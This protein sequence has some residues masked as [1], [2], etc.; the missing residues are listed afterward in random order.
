MK[1]LIISLLA[2][3]FVAFNVRANEENSAVFIDNEMFILDGDEGELYEVINAASLNVR[4]GPSTNNKII[5]KLQ[6]GDVISVT[7]ITGGWA[8][9]NLDGKT[10]YVS[11]AYLK[12]VE[13]KEESVKVGVSEPV[14]TPIVEHQDTATNFVPQQNQKDNKPSFVLAIKFDFLKQTKKAPGYNSFS[15][16]GV[17]NPFDWRGKR[18]SYTAQLGFLLDFYWHN[19]T[20][21]YVK[22]SSK[23]FGI[24]APLHLVGWQFN[25][26]KGNGVAIHGGFEFTCR[27]A[28][29]TKV[30]YDGSELSSANPFSKK[31]MGAG[32]LKHFAAGFAA[33]V[34]VCFFHIYGSVGYK[35]L[36]PMSK[37]TNCY[38]PYFLVGYCF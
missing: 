3:L 2:V 20:E 38:G 32:R 16:G 27:I 36:T 7:K 28:G 35:M 24:T 33:A 10:A 19:K 23:Y 11:K 37:E 22:T 25:D 5:G 15:I 13:K 6:K 21:H 9:F 17:T 4:S 1:K 34:D 8:R 30:Y 14:Q 31:D 26:G 18:S 12:K 29:T